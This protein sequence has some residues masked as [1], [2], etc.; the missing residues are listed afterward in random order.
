MIL[1]RIQR[2][3]LSLSS[4]VS[5]LPRFSSH[6]NDGFLVAH[7]IFLSDAD[8]ATLRPCTPLTMDW[9]ADV[10]E[11]R[12][13]LRHWWKPG[14][15][16]LSRHRLSSE[17][18]GRSSGHLIVVTHVAAVASVSSLMQLAWFLEFPQNAF[19]I[20]DRSLAFLLGRQGC[21]VAG[22]RRGDVLRHR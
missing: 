4:L 18:R 6:D 21:N 8:A 20:A 2:S 15:A 16:S 9:L 19:L 1:H 17:Q 12:P 22:L 7:L 3:I 13:F 5:L 11:S 10:G 14:N